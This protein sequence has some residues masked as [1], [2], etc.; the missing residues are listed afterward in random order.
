MK[1]TKWCFSLSFLVTIFFF[2]SS[3]AQYW[4]KYSVENGLVD[5]SIAFI[6]E[7]AKGYLW[8]TSDVNGTTRFDG[9]RFQIFT[10][11]DSLISHNIYYTMADAVGNVWFAT[12]RGISLYDGENFH[13]F[14]VSDGLADNTVNYIFQDTNGIFWLGTEN[15]ITKYDG[16]IFQNFDSSDGLPDNYISFILEDFEGNLWFSTGNGIVKFGGEK[17]QALGIDSLIDPMMREDKNFTIWFGTE[18]GIF[19]KTNNSLRIEGPLRNGN[20]KSILEDN[21]GNVWF[22]TSNVGVIRYDLEKETFDSANKLMEQN[23][24]CMVEDN[25]NNIWFGTD[26]GIFKYNGDNLEHIEKIEDTNLFYVK[27]IN[28]DKDHNLWFG[29]ESGVFKFMEENLW[30]FTENDGLV[31]NRAKSIKEDNDGN[32]YI[33]TEN[34]VCRFNGNQFFN[35]EIPNLSKNII[36]NS[37]LV[38]Q[39]KNLWLGTSTGVMKNFKPIPSAESKVNVSVK[40]ISQDG[41]GNIWFECANGICKYDGNNFNHIPIE[42]VTCIFIDIRNNLWVGTWNEGIFKYSG[43]QKPENYTIQNGLGSNH[44]SWIHQTYDESLW[45]GLKSSLSFSSTENVFPGGICRF[46]G[47]QFLNFSTKENLLSNNITS[48][49]EDKDGNLW[50]GTDVGIMKYNVNSDVT[51][52]NFQKITKA[53]GLIS[54]YIT[55][56]DTDHTGNLWFGSEKGVTKYNGGSFQQISFEKYLT[57]N[58]KIE[59]IYEDNNG[60]IWFITSRNGVIRYLPP[61]EEIKPRV[62]LTKIEADK[63]YRK[64]DTIR[65]P[66]ST[67]RIFIEYKGISFRTNPERIKYQHMLEGHDSEWQRPTFNTSVSYTNLQKK[68]YTFKVR[69]IDQD[70]HISDP[71]A[72]IA[73]EIY[74]P[75]SR[76]LFFIIISIILGFCFLGAVGYYGTQLKKQRKLAVRYKE[77]LKKQQEVE[78][79]QTAKMES[80]R[81]LVAGVAHELNTPIGAISSNNDTFKRALQ[82]IDELFSEELSF[83]LKDNKRLLNNFSVLKNTCHANKIASDKVAQIVVNLRSFVRLDEADW[84]MSDIHEGLNSSIALLQPEIESRI[85]VLKEYSGVPQAYC[86]PRDLNQVFITMLRNATEA[87]KDDGVIKV[88]TYE[89]DEK[90]NIEISDN[91]IGISPKDIDKIFDPGFTTKGVQVGV[92]LGLPICH[93]IVV[94]EHKGHIDVSSKLGKGS[95]FTIILPLLKEENTKENSDVKS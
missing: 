86:S 64:F 92:G 28:E 26:M 90:I 69:A 84:Q 27:C 78:N 30:H 37:I 89:K 38:D 88:K 10:T 11:N 4:T 59:G 25:R 51:K 36:V 44:I 91:G 52:F 95:T 74:R 7:D 94:D 75:F 41:N 12:D 1:R 14:N 45:F 73:F 39:D 21:K 77:R 83:E 24:L 85:K 31:D 65:V 81:Q 46:D 80:L 18:T 5:N 56:I 82:K 20:I 57:S 71:P 9:S 23:I 33:G 72:T 87:I 67:D 61:T 22:A 29:T 53:E 54:N 47:N 3:F 35:V 76:S 70:L 50:L 32:I 66:T 68:N 34:G 55:S 16:K 15:G 43:E 13:N 63:T 58:G 60:I 62:H 8:F 42:G 17:F 93:K 6:K 19:K 2:S 49:K 48:I 40:S 79:I